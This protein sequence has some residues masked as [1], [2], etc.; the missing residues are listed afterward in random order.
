MWLSDMFII[1]SFSIENKRNEW[2]RKNEGLISRNVAYWEEFVIEMLA[3]WMI[4][5]NFECRW[6]DVEVTIQSFL[7]KYIIK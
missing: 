5:M 2:I 1:A 7:M 4:W 3:V 6:N